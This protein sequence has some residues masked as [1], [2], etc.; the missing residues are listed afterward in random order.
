MSNFRISHL[1]FGGGLCFTPEQMHYI[2]PAL[3]FLDFVVQGEGEKLIAD[4]V[5]L[6]S[7]HKDVKQLK[8]I[9]A[10]DGAGKAVFSGNDDL[11]ILDTNCQQK[12]YWQLQ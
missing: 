5:R 2:E 6:A 1:I 11:D 3:S 7:E 9:W 12:V 8:Q 10:L 4:L